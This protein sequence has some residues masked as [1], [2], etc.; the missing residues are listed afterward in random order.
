MPNALQQMQFFR[1]D[2]MA[3]QVK[4]KVEPKD[5]SVAR[6]VGLEHIDPGSLKIRRWGKPSDVDSSKIL[7]RSGDII[8]GKRRAYQRK[9]AVA[10]FNGICSAHAMV[11]RPKTDVI[12]AEFLP[13]F[14]QSDIFMDRAVKISVGGL[15]PTIN[16]GDLA[17]EEFFLP[18]LE[19]QRQIAEVL[20]AAQETR[21]SLQSLKDQVQLQRDPLATEVIWRGVPPTGR[22]LLPKDWPLPSS[23]KLG[24]V[25]DVVRFRG[26]SQPPR[27]TFVYEA[28]SGY[29]RLLQI[30]DYKSDENLTFIPEDK[31]RKRCSV[32]DIMIGRYGPPLFQILRGLEGA[33]NVALIKAEPDESLVDR[34]YLYHFF[35]QS[36]LHDLIDHMSTRSAGQAGIEMDVLKNYPIPLPPLAVQAEIAQQFSALDVLSESIEQ[37]MAAIGGVS[38]CIS[39]DLRGGATA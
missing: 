14:M 17:K 25:D 12:L 31:A 30:R 19:E 9:L 5:A 1:F 35:R 32:E 34:E 3:T 16:W 4:D 33:Y 18:P 8:F 2:Q 11:L 37:R 20:Q 39:R 22:G 23:W 26:G 6:Y 36:R 15:S 21:E 28:Q 24:R 27:S 10:D 29:V 7:F 38:E 13:F